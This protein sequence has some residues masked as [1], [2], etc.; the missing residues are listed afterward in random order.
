MMSPL[1]KCV[2]CQSDGTY[3]VF[4]RLEPHISKRRR[5]VAEDRACEHHKQVVARQLK[6]RFPGSYAR[7]LVDGPADGGR[8]WWPKA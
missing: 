4:A 3:R 8:S 7:V 2:I 5:I 1:K 6:S